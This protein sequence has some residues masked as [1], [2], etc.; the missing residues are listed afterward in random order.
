MSR[1]ER[2]SPNTAP[3]AWPT[4]IGPVGLALTYSTL[5]GPSALGAP[6]PKQLAVNENRLQDFLVNLW[7]QDD[8][9][10]AGA[11]RLR[12]LHVRFTLEIGDE[13]LPQ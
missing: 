12:A 10:E 6:A 3:R 5:T 8:I 9:D 1:L 2:A 13:A 11:G 7:L 4:C